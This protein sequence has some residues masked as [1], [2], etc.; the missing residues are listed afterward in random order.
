V[1]EVNDSVTSQDGALKATLTA[2]DPKSGQGRLKTEELKAERGR[3]YV[4][5][6]YGE[7]GQTRIDYKTY[8]L[9]KASEFPFHTNRNDA[10][11]EIKIDRVPAD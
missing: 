6:T 8:D 11:K 10:I 5:V 9:R 2:F 7:A 4:T 3:F 1:V